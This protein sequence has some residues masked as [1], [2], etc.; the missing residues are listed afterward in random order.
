MF[1][2]ANYIDDSVLTML[3][4]RNEGVS[5]KIYTKKLSTQ[6]QLDI[7]KHNAQYAPIDGFFHFC[8]LFVHTQSTTNLNN[9]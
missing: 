6:L 3:D 9:Y 2:R 5:V 1:L 7:L 4:K 8:T